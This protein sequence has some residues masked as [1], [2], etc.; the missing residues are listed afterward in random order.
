VAEQADEPGRARPS[1]RR[2]GLGA[3]GA[4][5]VGLAVGGVA[6]AITGGAAGAGDTHA[7][8]ADQHP[9]SFIADVTVKGYD[10]CVVQTG[11]A[12]DVMSTLVV[13][14]K[15]VSGLGH[16]ACSWPNAGTGLTV[17]YLD[18]ADG[19]SLI[20]ASVPGDTKALT[21]R[22]AK[23]EAFSAVPVHPSG[24][25]EAFV[26]AELGAPLDIKTAVA[27]GASNRQPLKASPTCAARSEG[28]R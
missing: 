5:V 19:R 11:V 13:N 25:P 6:V 22:T 2:R 7:C 10:A 15:P 4:I 9:D 8:D 1:H 18:T 3:A 20:F 23:G 26:V 12:P 14:G 16:D 28:D 17:N 27:E 21:G 24:S